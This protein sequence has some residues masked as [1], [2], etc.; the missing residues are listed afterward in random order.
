MFG[1]P[2]FA[3]LGILRSALTCDVAHQRLV[4]SGIV[5]RL[6]EVASEYGP[7][8]RYAVEIESSVHT[9]LTW[10]V[11]R[12]RVLVAFLAGDADASWD[13]PVE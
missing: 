11:C 12:C 4:E 5:S 9:Q 6:W 7:Q 3:P 8:H 2:P 13:E 10:R 1:S